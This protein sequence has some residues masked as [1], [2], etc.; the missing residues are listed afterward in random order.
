MDAVDAVGAEG[1]EGA[2]EGG[3]VVDDVGVMVGVAWR[4]AP[5]GTGPRR[6]AA[7]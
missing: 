1:A 4:P 2:V 3:E 5:F 7:T 6:S